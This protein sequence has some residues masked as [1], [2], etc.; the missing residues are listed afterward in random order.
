MTVI[1]II[2]RICVSPFDIHAGA[3]LRFLFLEVR[4]VARLDRLLHVVRVPFAVNE[5]AR[6]PLLAEIPRWS[7]SLVVVP[8]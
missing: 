8:N 2:N 4:L 3:A 5:D 7:K 6:G 1:I